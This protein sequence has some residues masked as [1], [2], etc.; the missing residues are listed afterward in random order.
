MSG[1]ALL[2]LPFEPEDQKKKKLQEKKE[3]GL[4][5][6]NQVSVNIQQLRKEMDSLMHN[7]IF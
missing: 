5:E 6:S 4:K 7:S 3:R 2:P 1:I